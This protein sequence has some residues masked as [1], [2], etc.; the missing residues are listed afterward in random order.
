VVHIDR[1][2]SDIDVSDVARRWCIARMC[3]TRSTALLDRAS[4]LVLTATTNV[5]DNEKNVGF[6]GCL[7][8]LVCLSVLL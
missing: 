7:V 2:N 3:Q 1:C 8:W 6:G 5:D 4:A